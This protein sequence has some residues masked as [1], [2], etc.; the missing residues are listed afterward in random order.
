[1]EFLGFVN[2]CL[3]MDMSMHGW[4]HAVH[5][6]ARYG[7][8]T[9]V[10]EYKGHAVPSSGDGGGGGGG[11]WVLNGHSMS[12]DACFDTCKNCY[13]IGYAILKTGLDQSSFID[14]DVSLAKKLLQRDPPANLILT[15]NR[16]V[17][18]KTDFAAS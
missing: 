13:R 4:D 14:A 12:C 2:K 7:H 11:A 16:R 1:M 6:L 8:S 9:G 18:E 5:C 15:K 17:A 10:I 3:A